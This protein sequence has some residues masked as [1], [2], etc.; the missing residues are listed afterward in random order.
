MNDLINQKILSHDQMT[1][2]TPEEIEKY[3]TELKEG[4]LVRRSLG[5][6]GEFLET[7][8][9]VKVFKFEDFVKAM[10]FVNKIAQ[11][12]EKEGHHPDINIHYNKVE[13]VLWSH[14]INGLSLNDFIIAAKIDKATSDI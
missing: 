3:L 5:E 12:A 9:I 11:I 10:E 2:L 6:G 7:Q 13:I 4:W 14:Y 8:K 1:A